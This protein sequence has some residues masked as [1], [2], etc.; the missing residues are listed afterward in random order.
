M[1]PFE[2]FD[3]SSLFSIFPPFFLCF[4]GGVIVLMSTETSLVAPS[5]SDMHGLDGELINANSEGASIFS[6]IAVYKQNVSPYCDR[7]EVLNY[8]YLPP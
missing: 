4:P 7:E 8:V 6:D 5:V 2:A 1:Y 3:F